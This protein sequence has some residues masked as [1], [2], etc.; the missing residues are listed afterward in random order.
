MPAVV[1]VTRNANTVPLARRRPPPF[2]AARR[3]SPQ[4]RLGTAAIGRTKNAAAAPRVPRC[5]TWGGARRV[6]LLMDRW[7]GP[8]ALGEG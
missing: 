2:A 6:R 1:T 5:A 4:Q 8:G 3:H 7:D